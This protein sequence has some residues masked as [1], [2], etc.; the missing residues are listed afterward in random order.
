MKSHTTAESLT[1]PACKIIMRKLIGKKAENEIDKV[2]VSDNT[3]SRHVDGMSHDKDVLSE[4][5]KNTNFDLQYDKSTDIT[6]KA[7]LFVFVQ[8]QNEGE[9]MEIFV[10][11]KNFQE[12]LKVKTFSTPDLLIWNPAVC[13][14]TSVLEFALMVHP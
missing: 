11:V 7:L 9:N 14:G 6:N 4:I 5:K 10:V 13:N 12:Q 8:F 2:P 1:M 3:I